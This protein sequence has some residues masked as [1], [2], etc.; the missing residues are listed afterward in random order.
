MGGGMPGRT[1]PCP[2]HGLPLVW[3]GNLEERVGQRGYI[4]RISRYGMGHN[5]T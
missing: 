1:H 2:I 5:I 3:T 4:H